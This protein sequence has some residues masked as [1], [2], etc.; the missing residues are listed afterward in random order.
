MTQEVIRPAGAGPSAA[1]LSPGIK[2]NGFIFTSGNTGRV[3]GS[4]EMPEG[5][6]A[7]TRQTLE[8]IKAILEAGGSSMDKVV[9]CLIFITD[10]SLWGEMNEVYRTYFPTDRYPA[11]STVEVTALAGN[12]AIV[13]I[14]A[15]ALA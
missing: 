6:T 13:E 11:R 8:N 9:K 14:E 5:M 15:V 12:G 1:P 2:A 4:G 7:Q 10:I 3:P